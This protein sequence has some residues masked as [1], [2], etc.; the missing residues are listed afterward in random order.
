MGN[1]GA[2]SYLQKASLYL[3]FSANRFV[4]QGKYRSLC[5]RFFGIDHT[6][7]NNKSGSCMLMGVG[8][9]GVPS[10]KKGKDANSGR[11]T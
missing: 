10:P 9:S 8:F 3:V 5:L 4:F 1:N 6:N 2:H 7:S 11:K